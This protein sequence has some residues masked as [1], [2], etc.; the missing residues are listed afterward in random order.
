MYNEHPAAA[1]DTARSELRNC[2]LLDPGRSLAIWCDA[3]G[4]IEF[5]RLGELAAPIVL[6]VH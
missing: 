1:L 3:M 6:A 4:H 5:D 2:G